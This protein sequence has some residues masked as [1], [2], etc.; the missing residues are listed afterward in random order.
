MPQPIDL[1]GERFGRLVVLSESESLDKRKAW[2]CR[3]DCGNEKTLSS[4]QLRHD[5]VRSC[6]CLRK[7]TSAETAAARKKS[8]A[9][10]R[11]P[12]YN[13]WLC[14][15]QRCSN[16]KNPSYHNY[17]G[18]G[19]KVCEAWR[20]SF[21]AFL[22]DIGQPPTLKHTIERI[23]NDGDYEPENCRWAL[24]DEQLRNQRVNI[25]ITVNEDTLTA[26]DWA[27]KTGVSYQKLTRTFRTKGLAEATRLVQE[28]CA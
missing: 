6:G 4:K 27:A 15:L 17:G 9:K 28:S 13:R 23:N 5:K 11:D 1:T 25:L 16:P 19:V 14:M 3:C 22:E 12:L 18:R 2:L 7:E 20:E 10:R 26:K 24:R 8:E 21:D